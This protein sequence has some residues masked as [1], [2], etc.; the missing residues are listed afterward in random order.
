VASEPGQGAI[1]T[2]RLPWS[3]GPG[4]GREESRDPSG[5]GPAAARR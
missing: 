4:Q 3:K 2:V 5:G 1:F